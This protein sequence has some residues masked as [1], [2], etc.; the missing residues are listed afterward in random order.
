MASARTILVSGAAGFLGSHVAEA[1]AGAWPGDRLVVLDA[2][3]Y[4]GSRENLGK[5]PHIFVEGDI[6]SPADVARAF[7]Q[8]GRVDIVLHLAAESHVD[9][10]ISAPSVFVR[11]NVLGTQT[12]LDAALHH[13]ISRF[14]HISTDEVYGSIEEDEIL[15]DET[16]AFRPSSPYAASKVG[17]E[18][19]VAAANRTWGLDTVIARPANCF[20]LRQFPEKLIPVLIKAALAGKSLPLYGDGLYRRDWLAA[21]EFARAI[22]LLAERGGAG[23]AYNIPGSGERTN[24]SVAEAIC[25]ATN[26]TFSN[27]V[28][29]ADRPG[30]DRRYAMNGTKL[31][32]L[33]FEAKKTLEDLLPSMLSAARG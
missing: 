6:A 24:R 5:T 2:L 15:P 1:W 7:A 20:G 22:L 27:I 10:S 17:A 12:L 23:Q 14:V 3:T 31:K 28:R 18:A 8:A 32:A 26:T 9:R 30:H 25:Q 19:L 4:A 21:P 29:V 16:A 33:G 13:G 11:T